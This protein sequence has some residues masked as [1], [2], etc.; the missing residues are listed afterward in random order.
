MFCRRQTMSELADGI[1][2]Y[3]GRLVE[4][5]TGLKGKY[6]F[7]LA[8]ETEP[9]E[10]TTTSE[11]LPSIPAERGAILTSAVQEQL[12][13][14]LEAKEGRY[15]DAD[16]RPCRESAD[17]K[18]T[19]ADLPSGGQSLNERD[20]S[21]RIMPSASVKL[22]VPVFFSLAITAGCLFGSAGRLDWWNAWFFW[23]PPCSPVW[24]SLPDAIRS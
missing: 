16:D 1:S 9:R 7:S 12:G 11:G 15:R 10:A 22:L 4:D 14:K 24:R 18:L 23:E 20:S 19:A 21:R 17:G 3:A 2:S 6:D 5:Q 8:F 13:L